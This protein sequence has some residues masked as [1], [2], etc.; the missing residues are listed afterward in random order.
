[1]DNTK[2]YLKGGGVVLNPKGEVLVVCNTE[3]KSWFLPKGGIEQGED[4]LS[5]AKREIYEES[6]VKDL[7]FIKELG[8][9]E[10][11]QNMLGGGED[12]SK[13]KRIT[14]FLFKTNQINLTS[15]L[16][17]CESKWVSKEK[18]KDILTSLRDKEFFASILNKI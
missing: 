17:I 6:G 8:T 15:S 18:V 13:M 3:T 14:I 2:I 12:Q 1:M 9:Y 5:A 7:K 4:A 10:R 16:E 11:Y